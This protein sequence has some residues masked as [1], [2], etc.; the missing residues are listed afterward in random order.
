MLDGMVWFGVGN[1]GIDRLIEC[2]ELNQTKMIQ[3]IS[4]FHLVSVDISH[5][6]V[7]SLLI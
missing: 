2:S 3:F 4:H 1:G 6:S 5:K 7:F